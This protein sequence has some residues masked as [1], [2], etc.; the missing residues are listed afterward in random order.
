MREF[1]RNE[2]SE[3]LGHP[4]RSLFQPVS[5]PPLRGLVFAS[6]TGGWQ[7]GVV[8][9]ILAD[10]SRAEC[11][12]GRIQGNARTGVGDVVSGRWPAAEFYPGIFIGGFG[13]Q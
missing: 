10:E 13:S 3:I 4:E 8:V 6:W 2:E 11:L 7:R 5:A 12:S 9:S 1:V